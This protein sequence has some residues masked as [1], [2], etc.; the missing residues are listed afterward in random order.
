MGRS[1]QVVGVSGWGGPGQRVA[2][3]AG[4]EGW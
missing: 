3:V 1:G 2:G 4:E